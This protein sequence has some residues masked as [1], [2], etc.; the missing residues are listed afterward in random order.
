MAEFLNG[1]GRGTWG[2]LGYGE[3]AVPLNITAPAAGTTGTP[4]VAVNAQAVATV[5]GVTASLGSVSVVIQADANVTPATQLA[6]ANLGTATTTSVNNSVDGLASTSALGTTTLSTNNNLSIFGQDGEARLGN[7]SLVTNNNITISGFSSTSAVGSVITRSSNSVSISG[8]AATS[9]LGSVTTDAEA[10]IVLALDG[11][12]ANVGVV[13][14][15]GL[16]DD[17]QTPNWKEVA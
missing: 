5:G 16:I 2:Q 4:V 13:A 11:A 17:S 10:N 6:A 12:T 8:L 7:T 3:G 15:W 9:S 1:W 14:V